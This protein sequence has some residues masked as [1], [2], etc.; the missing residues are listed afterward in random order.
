MGRGMKANS[1]AD[2]LSRESLQSVFGMPLGDIQGF[3]LDIV[4]ASGDASVRLTGAASDL[5]DRTEAFLLTAR[6][7][8]PEE[9]WTGPDGQSGWKSQDL[10]ESYE[11]FG[12]GRFWQEARSVRYFL[13]PDDRDRGLG[14]QGPFDSAA[15]IEFGGEQDRT[16]ERLVLY[17]TP[18]YPCAIELATTVE[19]CGEI[20]ANLQEFSPQTARTTLVSGM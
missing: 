7:F 11:W 12:K 4:L 5:P 8:N 2:F 14:V 3:Y 17:A 20:L 1:L 16:A 15:A 18:E 9:W 19:R 13:D 10:L 6:D